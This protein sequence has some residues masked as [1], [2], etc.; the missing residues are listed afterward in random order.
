MFNPFQ[1]VTITVGLIFILE[2]LVMRIGGFHFAH[3]VIDS[4]LLI[5][6]ITPVLYYFILRPMNHY[7]LQLERA[8]QE[9]TEIN[10][11][12]EHRVSV[13]T[14]ELSIYESPENFCQLFNK[15]SDIVLVHEQEGDLPGR[16]IEVNEAAIE[17]LG[18]SKA[19]L[20]NMAPEDLVPKDILRKDVVI[21]IERELE[22][23]KNA[24]FESTYETKNAQRIF[25]EVNSTINTLG[26]KSV[27]VSVCRDITDRKRF[28]LQMKKMNLILE[29][30]VAERTSALTITM[31]DLEESEN[32]YRSL[33]EQSTEGIFI[34]DLHSKKIQEANT[35]LLNLLGYTEEQI[36]KLEIEDIVALKEG[37]LDA[38]VETLS[39]GESVGG[40]RH[41]KSKS[42]TLIDVE[43]NVSPVYYGQSKVCLANVRDIRDKNQ[44]EKALTH[45][46]ENIKQTLKETV[47]AL[48]MVTE[49]R[50]PYTAGHQLQVAEL[51]LAI[52][53]EM[54]L[55]SE[56]LEAI[57]MAAKLH[58]IGKIYVP[59]DILNKPGRLTEAEMMIIR[60]HPE[61]SYE[62]L[63]RIPFEVS[64]A[65]IVLQ[66]HERLDGSGYP[67]GLRGDEI[68][69]EAKI[70]AVADVLEAMSSHRPY[71]PTLGIEKALSELLHNQGTLYDPEVV[72]AAVI[73]IS[74][75]R[76]NEHLLV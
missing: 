65:D 55:S 31:K 11:E 26:G 70:L 37:E 29:E 13:K 2:F 36:I 56:Q 45:S 34:W 4:S 51:A 66:H 48:V 49:K 53:R 8:N 62:I 54:R 39:R 50:D 38:Y 41:Y 46:L 7:I 76:S 15:V 75:S 10:S 6:L 24:S 47:N 42:G 72:E 19:E 57:D 20:L 33:I 12:L 30:R 18:F 43:V 44:A 9:I 64:I 21:K 61:V 14:Q 3:A 22:Q 60:S 23:F 28:E 5:G 74:S 1:L 63:S 35:Q 40:P 71:R 68:L 67:K 17:K 58:D 16:I 73:V 69:L 27:V 59:S 52:G 25:V 32:R